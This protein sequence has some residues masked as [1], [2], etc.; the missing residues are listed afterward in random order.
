MQLTLKLKLEPTVEQKTLIGETLR[1]YIRTVNELVDM[2]VLFGSFGK[3][4][5]ANVSADLPSALRGQCVQDA[6][7]IYKKYRKTG[8]QP[9]LKKPVAIW[10]NQNYKIADGCLSFPVLVDGKCTR[11]SIRLAVPADPAEALKHFEG[12]ELG[13]LRITPKSGK[14]IAQIAIEAAEQ[15]SIGGGVLGVDLGLKC[16]AVCAA[17][18]GKVLFVGNGRRNK[19]IR[20]RFKAKR[21][22][23]G[24]AKKLNAIRQLNNKEQRIM[25][26]TDHK[27]SRRIVNFAVTNG[28][29]I[30]RLEQLANIR[31]TARTSRKNEKN[32]H[33]WSFYRL[34]QYIEY[35]AKLAGITVE[36]VNPAY[37]SQRC[38]VCGKLNHAKDRLYQCTC[39]FRSHRDLVGAI[40]ICSAPMAVGNR[41]SA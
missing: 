27:I 17:D 31:R 14:L 34:A 28:V 24:K 7:S 13:T 32:L 29:G 39:G 9:V 25:Q 30:I 41:Q 16:P 1:E 21:R 23:L 3:L 5:S 35:K 4:S 10:N 22:K 26:D 2:M 15:P 6:K 18:N 11:I 8:I 40:N 36:Y 20:R 38:P 33:T 19:Y 37:T 12:G